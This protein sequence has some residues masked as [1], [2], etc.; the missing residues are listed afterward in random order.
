MNVGEAVKLGVTVAVG[1][2]VVVGVGVSVR[3]V[4]GDCVDVGVG[5]DV[6]EAAVGK[7]QS[8]VQSPYLTASKS[9]CN[10]DSTSGSNSTDPDWHVPP[11]ATGCSIEA[12]KGKP[13]T[14]G[15]KAQSESHIVAT[16]KRS[17]KPTAYCSNSVASPAVI[18][19]L[20]LA[21]QAISCSGVNVFNPTTAIS[22]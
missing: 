22:T 3:V 16:G 7:R 4:V 21:S 5:V 18:V 9:T 12:P 2:L 14:D 15:M 17:I 11:A 20:P 10:A 13:A 1:V 6:G 19:P 8:P